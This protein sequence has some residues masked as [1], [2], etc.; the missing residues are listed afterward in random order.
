MGIAD[1]K[2]EIDAF[3]PQHGIVVVVEAGRSVMGN[4]IYRDIVRM[5]LMIDARCAVIAVPL[6]YKFGKKRTLNKA[7]EITVG[8]MN[9]IWSSERLPLP[10]EGMLLV[11]Y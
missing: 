2:Y 4:A 9:A 1:V 10:F 11:G 7:Y 3:H 5:S 6:E 8:A